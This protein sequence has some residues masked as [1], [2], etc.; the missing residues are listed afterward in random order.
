MKKEYDLSKMKAE[1]NPYAGQQRTMRPVELVKNFWKLFNEQKWEQAKSLL[2]SDL[3]VEWPQSRERM[4]GPV[5]FV[6]VNR[7]YPG[8]HKIEVLHAHQIGETV[9]TTVWVVSDTGQKTFAN[10]YFSVRDEKITHIEEYWAEPYAAPDWRKQW[11][12]L[13]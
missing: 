7:Y 9:V 6:E 1:E 10:S 3:V 12:E 13:Y 5:N 11:V 8:N 2:S 4:K